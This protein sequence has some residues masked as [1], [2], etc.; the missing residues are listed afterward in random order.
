MRLHSDTKT[1]CTCLQLQ[2][3]LSRYITCY[4]RICVG[5]H[6]SVEDQKVSL[7]L[8]S[9]THKVFCVCVQLLFCIMPDKTLCIS[10]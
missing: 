9:L 10:V 1:K 7:H 2:A 6:V 8:L 5:S 4:I 3:V